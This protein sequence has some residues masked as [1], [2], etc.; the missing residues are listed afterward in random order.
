VDVDENGPSFEREVE[1]LAD[2]TIAAE[3]NAPSEVQR[4]AGFPPWALLVLGLGGL[5]TLFWALVVARFA[6]LLF[7]TLIAT[8]LS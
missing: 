7:Q 8:I 2:R 5:A 6:I 4:A 3:A 1:R